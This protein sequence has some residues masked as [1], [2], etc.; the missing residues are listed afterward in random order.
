MPQENQC[1]ICNGFGLTKK[2][3]EINLCQCKAVQLDKLSE[4]YEQI[5]NLSN[6]EKRLFLS[7]IDRQRMIVE[8]P[9]IFTPEKTSSE[10]EQHHLLARDTALYTTSILW[11]LHQFFHSNSDNSIEYVD[12]EFFENL[13]S[14]CRIG[15]AFSNR[16][17]EFIDLSNLALHRE[18]KADEK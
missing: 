17:D 2:E 15:I 13:A 18:V 16:C 8:F 12:S 9:T 1:P 6:T 3:G 14:I 11:L 7:Y 4:I 5:K 10:Y